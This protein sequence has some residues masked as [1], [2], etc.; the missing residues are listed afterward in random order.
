MSKKS[1]K[2]PSSA[3]SSS[4]AGSDKSELVMKYMR[5]QNRPFGVAL[6]M[7]NL[8]DAV[9]KKELQ[10]I[11]DQE[12][13]K[14]TLVKKMFGSSPFYWLSQKDLGKASEAE[15]KAID[16]KIAETQNLLKMV[17]AEVGALGAAAK[18]WDSA[19]TDE[20]AEQLILQ[21]E[22]ETL[23]MSNRLK[24]LRAGQPTMGEGDR[25]AL[26]KRHETSRLEWRRRKRLAMGVID[27]LREEANMKMSELKDTPGI[28]TDSDAGV[29]FDNSNI[30]KRKRTK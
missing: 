12:A 2:G 30:E 18:M 4:P 5:E 13:E 20:E 6:L 9:G 21:L 16:G 3:S 17:Q 26:E 11:L 28:E 10:A 8:H 22:A 1:K 27:T 23:E 7:S 14:G 15:L 24:K 19:P 25:K 29:S